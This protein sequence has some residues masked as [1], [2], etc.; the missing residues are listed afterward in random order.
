MAGLV[1]A[2]HKRKPE[3]A[4][5]DELRALVSEIRTL[6]FI[7]KAKGQTSCLQ[8]RMSCRWPREAILSAKNLLSS[9]NIRH[10]DEIEIDL[11]AAHCGASV[12]Y[13]H[14]SHEEGHLL[15]APDTGLIVVDERARR[16][17]K[18][19]FVIAHEL[20]HFICHRNLDQLQ[21]C[22]RFQI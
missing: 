14:L 9:L 11:I 20:G 6:G 10:P 18:W 2:F 15:R 8:K 17:E 4:S 16:S 12:T 21:M 3:Q 13:R 1:G 19:R 7:I 5:T 22:H